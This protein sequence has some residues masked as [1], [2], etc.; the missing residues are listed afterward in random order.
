M[1]YFALRA[2]IGA[3]LSTAML[4]V[5]LLSR[6]TEAQPV[7]ATMASAG[8]KPA[9]M[10]WTTRIGAGKSPGSPDNRTWS[11]P[12]P[13]VEVA[14]ATSVPRSVAWGTRGC[15]PSGRVAGAG[16]LVGN[17]IGRVVGDRGLMTDAVPVIGRGRVGLDRS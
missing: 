7:A 6:K 2:A 17:D 10:C 13:P 15:G 4:G 9:V 3:A 5:L 12:G 16:A 8:V 11:A 1:K 14:M